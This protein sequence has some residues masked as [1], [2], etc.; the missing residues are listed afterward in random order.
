M[1]LDVVDLRTF[2]A[3]PLGDMV[4][5]LVGR[6]IR[7]RFE[8]CRGLCVLGI[9]YA[10]PYLD[11]L[12]GE[13]QRVLAFMPAE[14]GVVNW[15]PSG[16]SASSLVDTAALPLPDSCVDR[17]LLVHA[18]EITEHPRDL[19]AEVWRVLTPGGR[20]IAVAPSR[21][22]LWARLDATPFG[23]GQPYSRSQLRDLMRETLFSPTHWAEA[24]YVPPI[25]RGLVLRSAPAIER[26]GAYLAL[27]GAGVLIVEAT[28]QL[29][30]PVGLRRLARRLPQMQPALVPQPVAGAMRAPR[31]PAA[32]R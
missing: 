4:R 9:G 12:T 24:L 20:V 27:P 2:Y 17:V 25:G 5:R 23:H 19:L 30:R 28:K 14:Q 18:L 8:T 7:E 22:G 1:A 21:A 31:S 32:L 11:G 13:A 16:R 26:I 29:F 15:P 3:S 10:T 6:L